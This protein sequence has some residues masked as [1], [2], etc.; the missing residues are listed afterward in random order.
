MARLEESIDVAV[1]VRQAYDQWTQFERF[2]E[3]MEDVIEVR[4]LDDTRIRWVVDGGQGVGSVE[5]EAEI[6]EQ[7][8][9]Q[10]VAWTTLSGARHAGVV[11]FHRLADDYTR[12]MV[13]ADWEAPEDELGAGP[14][15]AALVRHHVRSDL[16]RFREF[17]EQ[18]GEAT[19]GW[20]GDVEAHAVERPH[21]L[22]DAVL[23][24]GHLRGM[25]V[26]DP[27][28]DGVGRISE[29][30]VEPGSD[31]VRYLGV[32]TSRLSRGHHVVPIDAVD[33]VRQGDDDPRA[34]IPWS[35]DQ[36][37]NAPTLDGD[38][39]LTR[40][41]RD[42]IS[43][44]YANVGEHTARRD[45]VRARQ[46]TPAPTP[47]IAEAELATHRPDEVMFERWGA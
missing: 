5:W 38:G 26:V 15:P 2:P 1:P 34:C 46:S 45:A 36:I 6:T 40:E 18:R 10:R 17:I 23:P 28:G 24:T 27:Q 13:Q 37:A 20:R 21:H 22:G 12:V 47:E 8:P 11:T 9:D 39:D 19:G 32:A 42:R 16:E 3:F 33:F 30:Y 4:Q 31:S 7:R 43:G 14:D 25:E 44:Y 29:V 35:R 41:D